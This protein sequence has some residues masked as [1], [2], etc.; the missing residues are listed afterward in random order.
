MTNRRLYTL[1]IPESALAPQSGDARQRQRLSQLAAISG[2]GTVEPTGSEP[3]EF[4]VEGQF[5]GDAADMLAREVAELADSDAVDSVEVSSTGDAFANAGYY[6]VERIQSARFRPQQ[7]K[8]ADYAVRLAREGTRDSHRRAI[9]AGSTSGRQVTHD[10]GNADVGY[11]GVPQTATDVRWVK[12]D[13][14]ANQTVGSADATNE[15]E[16][17]TVDL[18][19]LETA[20]Y[21]RPYLAYNLF[22]AD[23][24]NVDAAVFDTYGRTEFALENNFSWG[25]VFTASHEFTGVP[26]VETGV[27]RT[28]LEAESLSA[29]RWDDGAGAW[30]SVSLGTS[31]WVLDAVDLMRP[32]AAYTEAQLTFR[33]SADT[34]DASQGDLYRLNGYWHRGW[35]DVQFDIPDGESGPIPSDLVTLLDPIASDRVVNPRPT[36]ELVPREE[37][38]A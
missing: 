2:S 32:G 33:A 21:D 27:L 25:Q 18:Y 12:Y 11:M 1:T 29:E 24:G 15:A 4:R 3:G 26:V 37:L 22:Y 8:V 9:L 20:P 5:R 19:D 17:G 16:F 23:A 6:S 7:P 10:F 34:T 13:I 35:D 28:T 36:R 30:S 14:T 38:R 31:D